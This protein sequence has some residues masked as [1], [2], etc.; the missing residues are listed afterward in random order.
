[1][2]FT[3]PLGVTSVGVPKGES[4]DSLESIESTRGSSIGPGGNFTGDFAG[5]LAGDLAGELRIAMTS[6]VTTCDCVEMGSGTSPAGDAA[7][8]LGSIPASSP[9]ENAPTELP[10][11]EPPDGFRL[12]GHRSL[13]PLL[14]PFRALTSSSSSSCPCP[15]R[16]NTLYRATSSSSVSLRV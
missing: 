8:P 13:P 7:R 11:S 10:I 15:F 5:D 3:C 16:A 1:M 14:P 9:P 12:N 6:P 4:I 2:R